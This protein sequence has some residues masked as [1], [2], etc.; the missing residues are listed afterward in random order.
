M[1]HLFR[2]AVLTLCAAGCAT[3]PSP[4]PA[5]LTPR[6]QAAPAPAVPVQTVAAVAPP[7]TP[8]AIPEHPT[9]TKHIAPILFKNCATCHRPGEVA[10][11]PLLTYED[12]AKRA[13]QL[14]RVTHN[15]YMPPWKPA[16]GY[17]DFQ[18]ARVL[19]DA[20]IATIAAW[21]KQGA[22]QGDPEDLPP[23]PHFPDG[24]QLGTPDLVIQLPHPFT[25]PAEGRDVYQCF[26]IP[27]GLVRDAAVTGMEFRAGNRRVVHHAI[28]FLDSKGAAR[29]KDAQTPE[30]GYKCFGG[31]GFLASGSLGG[32]APGMTPHFLPEGT[33]RPVP[34]G[35]DLV[36][37]LHY[38]PDGKVETDQSQLG[39]Y[40]AKTPTKKYFYAFPLPQL[41]LEI[42][43]GESHYKTGVSF[44]APMD[45]DLVGVI[46]HMH[47]LGQEMKVTATLPDG[48]VK[49]LIYIDDWDFNWQGEYAFKS[50]VHVP[51]GTRFDLE[52]IYDNSDGNPNNPHFPPQQV[53]WGENTTDEMAL[54]FLQFVTNNPDDRKTIRREL[55]FQLQ[56]WRFAGRFQRP[57]D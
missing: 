31:P 16:P 33:A 18:D 12:A 1:N 4:P 50:P 40:F 55:F 57:T 47:L 27:M 3:P 22:P 37:Q 39:I 49:P 42:P 35:S 5:P 36:L 38:H 46:P 23:A 21:A 51:K 44:T 20:E 13:D 29:K 41:A 34:K 30:D 25:V 8:V 2:V 17:N 56:L 52:A 10:P 53:K 45:M 48:T 11:F 32:W 6:A 43:A 15:R 9:F 24:W 28:L 54:A 14:V 26:V 7:S 19:S